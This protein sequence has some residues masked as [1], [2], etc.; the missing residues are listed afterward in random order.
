MTSKFLSNIS[1]KCKNP[2]L[3]SVAVLST[4]LF[5]GTAVAASG[6]TSLEGISGDTDK[7]VAQK[8]D[9][10]AVQS[11][12]ATPSAECPLNSG[13]P[14]LLG[15]TWRL[16]SIYGTKVPEA[17]KIDMRVSTTSLTGF[18]GC[19]KY[20]ANFN[21]VGYTGF[22]VKKINKTNK[23]CKVFI[24]Y[25]GAPAI[26]IGTWEGSYIRTIKRMGSV[27]QVTESRL[28][29]FNRN[30]QVGMKYRK[31]ADENQQAEGVEQAQ[32]VVVVNKTPAP[33]IEK[34]IVAETVEK[35]V[36]Q[37]GELSDEELISQFYETTK[38]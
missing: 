10:G 7:T 35:P 6:S 11:I 24:P 22:T 36:A 26:N 9:S 25:P 33:A 23:V 37:K 2:Y 30:G 19:N 15:T 32:D 13:G 31:I 3:L 12:T 14:S 20:S 16:S 29:F 38:F 4:T 5:M 21:Q 17:L 27:R 34:A 8:A 28:H 18:S 1:L